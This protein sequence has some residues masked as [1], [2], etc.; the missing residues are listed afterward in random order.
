MYH[1]VLTNPVPKGSLHPI[2]GKRIYEYTIRKYNIKKCYENFCYISNQNWH[3]YWTWKLNIF[4]FE[5]AETLLFWRFLSKRKAF[6]CFHSNWRLVAPTYPKTSR[7]HFTITLANKEIT[8]FPVPY[9]KKNGKN[10]SG[11]QITAN[12]DS[13]IN[14][15]CCCFSLN[16][17]TRKKLFEN[18]LQIH[19][20]FLSEIRLH[21][22]KQ[23]IRRFWMFGQKSHREN[24]NPSIWRQIHDKKNWNYYWKGRKSNRI[25]IYEKDW[26][27]PIL[28]SEFLNKRNILWRITFW[29]ILFRFFTIIFSFTAWEELMEARNPV[30]FSYPSLIGKNMEWFFSTINGSTHY[31]CS[32]FCQKRKLLNDL[33]LQNHERCIQGNWMVFGK[34]LGQRQAF[35]RHHPPGRLEHL[36]EGKNTWQKRLFVQSLLRQWILRNHFAGKPVEK[37]SFLKWTMSSWWIR[38]RVFT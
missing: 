38:S 10:F 34:N 31:S 20:G 8:V 26:Y 3:Y 17:W 30:I 15:P 2:T 16:F 14:P 32:I 5:V 23:K 37:E 27:V 21:W 4:T 11:T 13:N 29:W 25:D 1:H 36:L 12:P 24:P 22:L 35:V 18:E 19:S 7:L 9:S 6:W 28:I 33:P